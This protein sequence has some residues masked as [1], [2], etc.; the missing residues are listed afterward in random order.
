VHNDPYPGAHSDG[1]PQQS[2]RYTRNWYA[3]AEFNLISS[4]VIANAGRRL[5]IGPFWL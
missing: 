1:F 3:L 2:F 5:R 4:G